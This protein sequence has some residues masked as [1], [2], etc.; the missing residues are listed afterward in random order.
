M[1]IKQ[2]DAR[3]FKL[4]FLR[5]SLSLPTHPPS[6][7]VYLPKQVLTDLCSDYSVV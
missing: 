2:Q 3:E 6:N 5:A 4:H 7:A 1:Q